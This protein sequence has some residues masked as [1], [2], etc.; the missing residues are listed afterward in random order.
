MVVVVE[1]IGLLAMGAA[2]TEEVGETVASRNKIFSCPRLIE[3][4]SLT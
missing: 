3:I 4:I 1:I 2:E